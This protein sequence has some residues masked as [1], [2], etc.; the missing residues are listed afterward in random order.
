MNTSLLA[1]SRHGFSVDTEDSVG[2]KSATSAFVW[3]RCLSFRAA[4]PTLRS[5][6]SVTTLYVPV[7]QELILTATS[8]QA[9][10]TVYWD[11]GD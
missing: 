6:Y 11:L 1:Q 9:R 4:H 3:S 8:R 2:Y 10:L 5:C 7:C